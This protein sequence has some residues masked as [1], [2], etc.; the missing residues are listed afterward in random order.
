M[1][2]MRAAVS[3]SSRF[4]SEKIK[5]KPRIGI[6]LGTG[7][8]ELAVKISVTID[9]PYR[10]IPG[11]P[12]S[13]VPGHAGR[14]AAGTLGG[15]EVLV[16]EGRVHFYEGYDLER[17][18]FPVRVMRKV[19][20]EILIVSNAAGALNPNYAAGDVMVIADHINLTG[21]NPLIGPNLE[22]F[23]PRFPDM[24]QVYDPAL[25]KEAEAAALQEKV[26]LHKGIYVGVTGPSMETP[27]ETRFL[28]MTG[29]D[30]VG[31]STIPEVIVAAHCG[32]RVL[33]FS[34]ISN[35]N[36][37]DCMKPAPIEE[38]LANAA[39]AGRKMIRIIER[40]LKQVE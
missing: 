14:L 39:V 29:A 26:K 5:N 10:E 18:T 8:G 1:E 35:V 24:T 2:E 9:L 27:A 32:L 4:I 36:L 37:P 13:T 21:Q 38:V 28:R 33:A 20:I 15:K 22:D 17:V 40:V 6:I 19:G 11:F 30:A 23:G 34:A 25:I 12:R 7:L 16:M 3:E 31:M